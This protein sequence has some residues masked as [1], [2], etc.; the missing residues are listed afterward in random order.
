MEFEI[1]KCRQAHQQHE[2]DFNLFLTRLLRQLSSTCHVAD[3]D[4]ELKT[5]I[6]QGC[7]SSRLRRKALSDPTMTHAKM[8]DMATTSE[9]TE[10]QAAGMEAKPKFQ[11]H[12]VTSEVSKKSPQYK[13]QCRNCGNSW[14]HDGGR[15]SCPAFEKACCKCLKEIHL[16]AICRGELGPNLHQS[17]TV[18]RKMKSQYKSKSRLNQ[19]QL[20][21]TSNS[22]DGCIYS[23]SRSKFANQPKFEVKLNGSS[24]TVIADSG[25]SAN[26]IDEQDFGRLRHRSPLSLTT[27]RVLPY[28]SNSSLPVIGTFNAVAE[29]ES[30]FTNAPFFVVKG[31]SGS[32]LSWDTS[33][34]WRLID[35]A[36]EIRPVNTFST[37][38]GEKSS[39]HIDNL[40]NE[41]ADL[42]QWSKRLK[43]FKV[44]L[45]IEETIPP[46]AQPHRRW[47]T[48]PSS[49]SGESGI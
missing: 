36:C 35:V 37:P 22:G 34:K 5:Q 28:G 40:T 47:C 26:I 31:S 19:V 2:E 29:F 12:K 32:L 42:F 4:R 11:H 15:Q 44:K 27:S 49:Q 13:C 33:I 14:P 17:D 48:V 8:I 38:C 45:R 1:Y 9:V 21:E 24:I 23:I 3:A 16:E 25:A 6:I 7:T 10:R 46:C 18:R 41:Y 43:N 20:S 30:N 39:E